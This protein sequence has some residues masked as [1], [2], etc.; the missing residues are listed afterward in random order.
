MYL[1]PANVKGRERTDHRAAADILKQDA[2][3]TFRELKSLNSTF[4]DG[5]YEPETLLLPTPHMR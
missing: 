3:Q 4:R 5:F 2:G 1:Y